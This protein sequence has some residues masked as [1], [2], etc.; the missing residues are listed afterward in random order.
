MNLLLRFLDPQDQ[1]VRWRKE[2][3]RPTTDS[4]YALLKKAL[5]SDFL[6]LKKSKRYKTTVYLETE[7]GADGGRDLTLEQLAVYLE[8]PEGALLK[9]ERRRLLIEEFADDPEAQELVELQLDPEGYNGRLA[10]SLPCGPLSAGHMVA[11]VAAAHDNVPRRVRQ[12]RKR[13][14]RYH[15]RGRNVIRQRGTCNVS[16]PIT[17]TTLC[18]CRTRFSSDNGIVPRATGTGAAP[19]FASLVDSSSRDTQLPMLWSVAVSH[20][21]ALVTSSTASS[22]GVGRG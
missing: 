22:T 7:H 19:V 13:V 15:T 3:G 11:F 18:S 16:K 10:G 21:R 17:V 2:R 9:Q 8:T 1:T 14:G 20:C 4:V 6:D 5:D 12:W